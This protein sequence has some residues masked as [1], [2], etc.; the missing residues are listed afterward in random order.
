MST[1]KYLELLGETRYVK[2]DGKRK[3]TVLWWIRPKHNEKREWL[4]RKD[5]VTAMKNKH[6]SA[7]YGTLISGKYIN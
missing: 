2:A 6:E 5:C 7:M 4:F 3:S 1:V